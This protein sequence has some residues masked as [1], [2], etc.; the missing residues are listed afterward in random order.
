MPVQLSDL[1]QKASTYMTGDRLHLVEQAY[2]FAEAQHAGQ[3]RKS[4]EPYIEH[5]LNA[6]LFLADLRQDS[7]TLAAALLHDVIED[8]AM[9]KEELSSM[10]GAEVW[11]PTP[12]STTR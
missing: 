9:S 8:T 12:A 5:P 6:A 10:F 7:A 4:G 1:L 2:E 3:L 11:S